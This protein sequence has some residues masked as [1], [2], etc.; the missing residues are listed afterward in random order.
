[1]IAD[2]LRSLANGALSWPVID[3]TEAIPWVEQQA[4]IGLAES[5]REAVRLALQSKVLVDKK[6]GKLNQ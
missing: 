2:R 1:M 4:E 5:Q 3:P 6:K